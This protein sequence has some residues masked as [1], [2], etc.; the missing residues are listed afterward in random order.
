MDMDYD[1][2]YSPLTEPDGLLRILDYRPNREVMGLPEQLLE[3]MRMQRAF[4]D[5]RLFILFGLKA[6]LRRD[7]L[8]GFLRTIRYEKLD[9]LLLDAFQRGPAVEGEALTIID[10]DLCILH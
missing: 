4:F 5:K 2:S 8:T 1:N 6:I 10:E 3:Y 7:E 9:V